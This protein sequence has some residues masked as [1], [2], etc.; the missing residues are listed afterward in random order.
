MT[1]LLAFFLAFAFNLAYGAAAVPNIFATQPSGNVPA[2]YLDV[3]FALIANYNTFSNYLVDTG[4]ANV[5]VVT[6]PAGTTASLAAGLAIQFKASADNSGAS[7][8]A[9][10]GMTAKSITNYD[11]SALSSGQ[12]KN[13]AIVS[14]IYD[15]TQFKL[16]GQPGGVTFG[17]VTGNASTATT[18]GTVTTAAQPAITSLGTLSS[19]GVTGTSTLGVVNSGATT[20]TG[21]LTADSLTSNTNVANILGATT[22][23]STTLQLGRTSPVADSTSI[24]KFMG[25]NTAVNWQIASNNTVGSAL[26]F[27]PSTAGGGGTFTTPVVK[28]L[29]TG[30]A[31]TG[32]L[33]S[34]T[35]TDDAGN[36][37]ISSTNPTI[38]SG[39]GTSP[40]CTCN[41]TAAFRVVIGTGP[42]NTGT[43][44]MPT[45]PNGWACTGAN[46]NRVTGS[47]VIQITAGTTSL[48][49]T[50]QNI[51]SLAAINFVAGDNIQFQCAAF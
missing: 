17:N 33:S 9:V 45:A 24:L 29:N 46:N 51:T 3:D 2:S 47:G 6:L 12:I 32:A 31:V 50:Q 30:L 11:A 28:L 49:V 4:V 15:G 44:T 21:S 22:S 34:T 5:Y 42:G 39:F 18:A 1:R 43:V 37:I 40:T 16:A 10:N 7:T 41:N 23:S 48:A 13:G 26:E 14:V 20:V 27:T 19:L 35:L 8:L 36:L 25:S 38:A